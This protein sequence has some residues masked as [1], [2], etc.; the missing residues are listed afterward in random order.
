M[1]R[2]EDQIVIDARLAEHAERYPDMARDMRELVMLKTE[3]LSAEQRNLLSV[4]YKNVVGSARSSWRI[5]SQIESK[6]DAKGTHLRAAEYRQK[7]EGELN[8]CCEEV[9]TLI[10]DH[11]LKYIKKELDMVADEEQKQTLQESNVFYLKMKGDYYRYQVEVEATG[12][13]RRNELAELSK[14]AYEQATNEANC[15]KATHPIKLGLALNFSVFYY[16]IMNDAKGACSMAKAAFDDA[17]ADLDSLPEDSYKDST[18]IM[19]LLRDNLTL[20]TSD[21]NG[22]EPLDD[23]EDQ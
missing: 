14:G 5:L 6:E 4:A 23:Q 11:L 8:K 18:L 12:K 1:S 13:P 9:L 19:Q 20:W 17:I 21:E 2:T 3:T 16:E 7:V 15:F 10:D 22:D